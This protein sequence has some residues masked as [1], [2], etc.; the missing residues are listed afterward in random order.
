MHYAILAY[1]SLGLLF[2]FVVYKREA[3]D[4]LEKARVVVC[5]IAM[6]ALVYPFMLLDAALRRRRG[7]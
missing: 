2:A 6:V 7:K 5:T 4:D 1:L 3:P